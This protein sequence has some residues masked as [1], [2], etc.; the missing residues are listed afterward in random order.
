MP[1]KQAMQIAP[2]VLAGDFAH[3]GEQAR[4]T[5]LAG[6]DMLHLDVMD[7]HFVPNITFGAPVI[8][9]MRPYTDIVFDVHLMIAQ[10]LRYV[11]DF[12][13]AGA[14]ILNFHI[15]SQDDPRDVI[16]AIVACGKRP[17]IT[18]K[19]DT[20][21]ETVYPYLPLLD[22]V[23]VM[24]VEPGFGGQAFRP[25]QLEK[26]RRLRETCKTTHPN[27]LIQVD[28]GIALATIGAA[29][30]AGADVFVAGSAVYGAKDP[31][32]AI[33]DLRTAAEQSV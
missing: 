29:A 11:S 22:M 10:P 30:Q 3:L 31:A 15:E 24:T 1:S 5:G 16:D 9:A 19:P 32:K 7:G 6:A 2:S 26:V 23:L 33:A 25:E 4:Q 17:A 28:G 27:L 21:I 8:Q 14:D 18:V 20:P 12:A 13:A